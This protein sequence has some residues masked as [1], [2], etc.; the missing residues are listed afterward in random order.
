[1]TK[2]T[3][4]QVATPALIALSLMLTACG[5]TYNPGLETVHQP[6]VSRL[7]YTLDLTTGG[8]DGLA[9]GE[10]QWRSYLDR[11]RLGLCG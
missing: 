4:H 2:S 10:T 11:W 5:G 3:V 7:D 1:M 6:V 8:G 9:G